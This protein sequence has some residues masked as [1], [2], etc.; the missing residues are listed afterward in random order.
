MTFERVII[1][2]LGEDFTALSPTGD[3]SL[4]YRVRKPDETYVAAADNTGL[5]EIGIGR[6]Q[7]RLTCDTAW[8]ANVVLDWEIAGTPLDGS[9]PTLPAFNYP[10]DLIAFPSD[11]ASETNATSNKDAILAAVGSGPSQQ[12]VT[13]EITEEETSIG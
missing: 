7:L 1:F 3:G 6:Y 11:P 4:K 8:G 5:T 9:D 2:D 12:N 13:I 10:I